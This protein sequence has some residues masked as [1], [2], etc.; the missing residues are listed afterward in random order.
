MHVAGHGHAP[1]NRYRSLL[2]R[3]ARRGSENY[4]VFRLSRRPLL[5]RPPA[6]GRS[7]LWLVPVPLTALSVAIVFRDPEATVGAA[8]PALLV[9]AS[10][11][12]TVRQRK[13]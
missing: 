7:E 4:G 9:V 1:E 11:W 5:P 3:A 2:L 6:V 12:R 13:P 10:A 8:L